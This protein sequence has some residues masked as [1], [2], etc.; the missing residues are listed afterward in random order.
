MNFEDIYGMTLQE[1][2]NRYGHSLGAS[3][4]KAWEKYEAT[5]RLPCGCVTEC[6]PYAH[7]TAWD[8]DG[9]PDGPYY[10]RCP[11]CDGKIYEDD[12]TSHKCDE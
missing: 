9:T 10:T 12:P 6:S 8:W 5:D 7:D 2:T 1:F 3:L 11:H 4:G